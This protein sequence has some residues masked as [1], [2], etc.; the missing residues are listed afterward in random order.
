[1]TAKRN[2]YYLIG[3]MGSGKTAVGRQLARDLKREFRDTDA[4]IERRT[5][6]D[7]PYIFEKEGESGFRERE[8]EVVASLAELEN[9]VVATGGGAVLDPQNRAHLKASG[10]VIYLHTNVEEQ[11][12]RTARAQ[13]RP[14]LMNENPRAVLERLMAVRRPIY[15]QIA[16]LSIDTTGRHVIAV[17][18]AVRRL[19]AEHEMPALKN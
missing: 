15:E 13:N 17:A 5:G 10:T 4:E 6:V 18:F 12:K 2:N 8:K 9:L 19:L 16:D 7:I 1:M 11:L 14:L 3:P